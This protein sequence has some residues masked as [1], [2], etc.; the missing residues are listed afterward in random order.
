[1]KV[2]LSIGGWTYSQAQASPASSSY[3]GV[4]AN[5]TSTRERFAKTAV[6][7][8]KDWGLDG[9]D[10]DW[11]YPTT[12]DEGR[13][14]VL[15]LKEIRKELDSYAKEHAP[16]YKFLLSIAAPTAKEKLQIADLS[17]LDFLDFINLMT[18]DFTGSFSTKTGHASNLYP[19][20]SNMNSTPFNIAGAVQEYISSGFPATKISLGIPLY[21]HAFGQT[22]GL[23]QPFTK[24]QEGSFGEAGFWDYKD[25][26]RDGTGVS[27]DE[28][29]HASYSHSGSN[30]ELVSF[31]TPRTVKEKA[32][33]V[34]D[35]GLA[36]CFFWQAS[37]DKKNNESLI[38]TTYDV[39]QQAG[40]TNNNLNYPISKYTNI[41][42]GS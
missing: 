12:P 6:E 16:G 25:L 35:R 20:Q 9:I 22:G 39:L 3:Y 42:Q 15:L 30:T 17:Q 11:E 38:K 34:K 41:R 32:K 13:N 7:F 2:M 10:I 36:G 40:W 19:S 29:A 21:G 18:Y 31:E 28:E 33:Y 24:S 23:G 8:V 27:Y 37:S 4:A 1:M 5:Q 26:P 14:Y